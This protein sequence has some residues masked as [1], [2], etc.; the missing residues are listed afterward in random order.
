MGC[1]CDSSQI[2]RA[3][4][5]AGID[6][7]AVRIPDFSDGHVPV[8]PA[9]WRS[10]LED[11][12]LK[13][14][15]SDLTTARAS[16]EALLS[17]PSSIAGKQSPARFGALV[18]AAKGVIGQIDAVCWFA[19]PPDSLVTHEDLRQLAEA[20]ETV[21]RDALA[22]I[23]GDRSSD[24]AVAVGDAVVDQIEREVPRLSPEPPSATLAKVY[25]V[26]QA[27][28]DELGGLDASARLRV[29]TTLDHQALDQL[30]C[31][32]LRHLI[33]P[34]TT[35]APNATSLLA[36]MLVAHR[37]LVAH[38]IASVTSQEL[39]MLDPG[40]V[41]PVLQAYRA[42]LPENWATHR[43]MRAAERRA[44]AASDDDPEEAALAEADMSWAF[45]EGPL[46]RLGWTWLRLH[47]A[48]DAEI[49]LLT[50]LHQ[51]LTARSGDIVASALATAIVPSWR[52]AVAHR[53]VS[54][55]SPRA[56]LKM[57]ADLAT[58][59]KLRG[60]RLLGTAVAYGFECGVAL[61][62]ASSSALAAELPLGADVA[63]EPQLVRSRLAD[64][65]A[66]HR[67]RCERVDVRDDRVVVRVQ[68]LNPYEA[69]CTLVEFAEAGG[70]YQLTD[71]ELEVDQRPALRV[72][73]V[74]LAELSRLRSMAS[75]ARLPAV[76]L[77][78]V[79]AS[80]RI[81]QGTERDAI[82]REI[83][84]RAITQVLR[85]FAG[86]LDIDLGDM[87]VEDLT[88]QQAVEPLEQIEA[89]LLSAWSVLPGD[90]P[91]DCEDVLR[92]I[93]RVRAALDD[94]GRLRAAGKHLHERMRREEPPDLPWFVPFET[95]A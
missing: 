44:N 42:Y 11:S 45:T 3:V 89:A 79:I 21:A 18:R 1:V 51:R 66:Q 33:T 87:V 58:P 2:A 49:P 50:E 37:P 77:W 4:H 34:T 8:T 22:L 27:I 86:V 75:D 6:L 35:Y 92:R 52:N 39:L 57:G 63:S 32:V 74:V 48:T 38:V 70:L 24:A 78:V 62:R 16:V 40:R 80:G 95:A 90:P 73:G 43:S 76:A 82:Y 69:A 13:K 53:E 12:G 15:W 17:E 41:G 85:V 83:A 64:L 59:E 46:R 65:M 55:D 29:A 84:Q 67:V 94:P 71:V 28:F 54:Y 72:P 68:Q 88:P 9:Q 19:A 81:D 91:D 5:G 47:G 61:A 7:S 25:G 30:S 26:D 60:A 23:A 20:A 93:R 56:K 36:P 14:A 10:V 31:S